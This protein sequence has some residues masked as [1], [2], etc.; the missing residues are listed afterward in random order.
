M[1]SVQTDSLIQERFRTD[2]AFLPEHELIAA[3]EALLMVADG[4]VH[5][6]DIAQA[7]GVD[8]RDIAR[9]LAQLEMQNGRGWILQHHAEHV[10][11]TTAPRFADYVRRFLGI[12]R[13]SRLS[14]AALESLAIVAYRQ[15]VTRSEIE[16]VRGV[17]CTGVLAT[18]MQRNLVEAVGRQDSPGNP[19]LYG[20]TPEFLMHFGLGSL[21][22]LPPLGDVNGQDANLHLGDLVAQ[23]HADIELSV[24][25]AEA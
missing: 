3:I 8:P 4:P 20:T 16:S 14:S 25:S 6:A 2:D 15:P 18:L 9:A 23:A 22:E 11:L 17:D 19:I 10:Q 7:I 5:P 21:D 24:E 1:S 13:Q 12:E